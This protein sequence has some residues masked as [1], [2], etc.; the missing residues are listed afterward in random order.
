MGPRTAFINTTAV[1]IAFL[2]AAAHASAGWIDVVSWELDAEITMSQIGSD[3]EVSFTPTNPFQETQNAMVGISTAQS[4]YDVSWDAAG[5][6]DFLVEGEHAGQGTPGTIGFARST[7]SIEL[8][9]AVDST[10]VIDASY[11]FDLG[12]GDR[13][14]ELRVNAGQDGVGSIFFSRQLAIPIAGDPPQGTFT[15]Q[16]TLPLSGGTLYGIG[17]SMSLWSFGGSPSSLSLGDGYVHFS[18]APVC[19]PTTCLLLLAAAPVL[20]RRRRRI[21]GR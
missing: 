1:L 19:E 9:P 18:I 15:V 13:E 17:Y 4:I 8:L 14:A 11:Q 2:S 3:G 5:F 16:Q 12:S 20:L 10:L 6:L 7:G 21:V